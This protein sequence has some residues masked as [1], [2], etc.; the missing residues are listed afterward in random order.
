MRG[1]GLPASLLPDSP[2]CLG[3][4]PPLVGSRG[5]GAAPALERAGKC[6]PSRPP[7]VE[8][9]GACAAE[10]VVVEEE[11]EEEAEDQDGEYCASLP[12]LLA[13]QA[14]CSRGKLRPGLPAAQMFPAQMQC[15]RAGESREAPV[16]EGDGGAQRAGS[17]CRGCDGCDGSVSPPNGVCAEA[18]QCGSSGN[19]GSPSEPPGPGWRPCCP[20]GR[21]ACAWWLPAHGAL[22]GGSRLQRGARR[23]EPSEAAPAPP[24]RCPWL[25]F[26]PPAGPGSSLR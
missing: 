10:A 17:P 25:P 15:R 3:A 14:V 8:H 13:V 7:P 24:A 26:P 21:G 4:H 6:L 20:W 22:G 9:K 12:G 18:C 1:G 19:K 5:Q 11:E 2:P 23:V 16:S